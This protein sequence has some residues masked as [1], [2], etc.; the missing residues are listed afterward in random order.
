MA[1]GF[2]TF[3]VLSLIGCLALGLLQG[4]GLLT[5]L[6]ESVKVVVEL[7]PTISN[8]QRIS[9]EEFLTKQSSIKSGSIQYVS[10][11]AGAALLREE[12]GEDFLRFDLENPLLDVYSFNLSERAVTANQLPEL[13]DILRKQDAVLDLYVQEDI[14]AQLSERLE[15]IVLFSVVIALLLLI[16]VI[17]L[18]LNTTRLALLARA[19]LIKNMELVGASWMF[20][21]APFLRRAAWQGAFAGILAALVLFVFAAFAKTSFPAVWIAQ[22][23]TVLAGIA[24]SLVLLGAILNFGSTF[25]VVRR[26]LR[27]RVDD[28]MMRG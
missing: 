8:T 28:L 9:F 1:T 16:A 27:M 12:F 15:S 11:D 24:L 19:S 26:T 14:A 5:R 3:I 23:V 22:S 20:I 7:R 25:V 18:M 2:A 4:R 21:S 17:A 6:R 10:K 13:E